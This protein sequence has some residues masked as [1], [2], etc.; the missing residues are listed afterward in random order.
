MEAP[1]RNWQ[2]R[3]RPMRNLG[4]A[5]GTGRPLAAPIWTISQRAGSPRAGAGPLGRCLASARRSEAR[6][7]T[8]GFAGGA[9]ANRRQL[10]PGGQGQEDVDRQGARG[11]RARATGRRGPRPRPDEARSPVPCR[12][13]RARRPGGVAS[14]QIFSSP[15]SGGRRPA[16]RLIDGQGDP[17]RDPL[18]PWKFRTSRWLPAS[19]SSIRS[20]VSSRTCRSFTRR[21]RPA[22]PR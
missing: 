15:P 4:P 2:S 3:W 19:I 9:T 7:A 17:A 21:G 22:A 16:I 5:T 20:R 13:S 11:S 1:S 14:P 8:V 6:P 18:D 10:G 12:R